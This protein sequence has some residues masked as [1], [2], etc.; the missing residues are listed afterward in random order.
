MLLHT[1]GAKTSGAADAANPWLS[2]SIFLN[3]ELPGMR[4]IAQATDGLLTMEDWHNFGADYDRTLMAWHAR[5]ERA[6]PL[7]GPHAQFGHI[8]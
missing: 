2:R 1:I 6:W 4:Q 3:G 7:L 5:I 8:D